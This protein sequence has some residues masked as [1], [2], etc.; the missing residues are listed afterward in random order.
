MPRGFPE[1]APSV[2]FASY[3]VPFQWTTDSR[4][5][6]A[7]ERAVDTLGKLAGA[8]G[9]IQLTALANSVGDMPDA[10]AAEA[11][12]ALPALLESAPALDACTRELDQLWDTIDRTARSNLDM[13]PAIAALQAEVAALQFRVKEGLAG[14]GARRGEVLDALPLGSNEGLM[15]AAREELARLEEQAVAACRALSSAQR[16]RA[17]TQIAANPSLAM[18]GSVVLVGAAAGDGGG[19]AADGLLSS[20]GGGAAAALLNNNSFT[21]AGAVVSPTLTPLLATTNASTAGAFSLA[22]D[23]HH[24]HAWGGDCDT[25]D[26][27]ET[28][29]AVECALRACMEARRAAL[30]LRRYAATS[31]LSPA[32]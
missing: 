15:R 25:D 16:G 23:Q 31:S 30:L 1:D 5:P 3:R 22:P 17:A 9:P 7:V 26:G 2:V 4:L 28:D 29:R 20:S 18:Q 21:T 10:A 32:R 24:H 6:D 19:A 12:G 14:L 13:Q 27:D 8:A 11:A